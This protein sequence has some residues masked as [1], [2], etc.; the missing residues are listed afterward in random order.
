MTDQVVLAP[1]MTVRTEAICIY[2]VSLFP[3][4][5]FPAHLDGS[6]CKCRSR[7]LRAGAGA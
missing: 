1:A 5:P 7:I 4:C 2:P 6:C 3:G